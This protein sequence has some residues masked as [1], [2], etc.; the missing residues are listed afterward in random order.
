[1][2]FFFFRVVFMSAVVERLRLLLRA[3]GVHFQESHHQPVYTSEE[4]AAV[5][6]ASLASGAKAL[7]VKADQ[8]FVL[9]VIPADRKLNS[10]KAKESLGV[11]ELRFANKEELQAQTGLTPGAVP[12]FGSLFGMPTFVDPALGQEEK[13]NFNAGDQTISFCILWQEYQKAEPMRLAT[14]T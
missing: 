12:P 5:R 13:I 11:K 10:K 4:A 1:M 6:R 7:L 3:A 9:L 8:R 2:R 14:L